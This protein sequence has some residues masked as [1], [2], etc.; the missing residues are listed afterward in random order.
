MKT[1]FVSLVGRDGRT[2]NG[3]FRYYEDRADRELV[4]SFDGKKYCGSAD[5]FFTAIY[6]IRE[7]LKVLRL[8]SRPVTARR[9]LYVSSYEFQ[10]RAGDLGPQTLQFVEDVVDLF[11]SGEG[12][13]RATFLAQESFYRNW[14]L[15]LSDIYNSKGQSI[16]PAV[17]M[18]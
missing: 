2:R 12:N 10:R 7:K 16:G 4:L 11:H 8:P 1:I 3:V 14:L 17:K 6:R 18:L 5:E 9:P 13:E 15:N